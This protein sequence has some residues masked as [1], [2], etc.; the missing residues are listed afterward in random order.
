MDRSLESR[1]DRARR[2]FA[3]GL[4][5]GLVAAVLVTVLATM[6]S[7]PLAA[8]ERGGPRPERSLP[9]L[10][11]GH[12]LGLTRY[13]SADLSALSPAEQAR[14][15][16][17]VTAG[18]GGFT[19]YVDW[20]DLEP[21]AGD[22]R[23]DAVLG[24]LEALDA[25]GLKTYLNITVGDIGD[26]NLPEDLPSGVA[27]DDPAVTARFGALLDAFVPQLPARGVFLLGLG[28]EID[29]RLDTAPAERQAYAGFIEAARPHIEAAAPQLP[30]A[31]T[32]TAQALRERSATATLMRSMVDV[33]A[34]NYAPI[35][36]NLFVRD[37]AEIRADFAAVAEFVADGPIVIQELTCPSTEAMNASLNWQRNCFD[38]ILR[39][40]RERPNFR[41]ASV[42]TLDDF[43]P[44]ECSVVFDAFGGIG[45]APDDF[46]ERFRAYL[47]HLG[48]LEP[49]GD[50][51]PAWRH[52][53]EHLERQDS[54]RNRRLDEGGREAA[55]AP[56]L[57]EVA[58]TRTGTTGG[59][60]RFL[61]H[62]PD[63]PRP[64]PGWPLV[65]V[66]HG[67]GGS[68]EATRQDTAFDALADD[69]HFVVAFGEA[70]RPDPDAPP[71][72]G[73]NPQTWN[74]GSGRESIGAVARNEDDIGYVFAMLEEI[75]RL[76]PIDR[77]RV[78]AT[79]FSNGAGMTF[80]LARAAPGRFA[81]VAPVAGS[82]FAEQ[83]MPL[84]EPPSLLYITG[85]A[86]PLNPLAGGD[87]FLFGTFIGTKPPVDTLIA[88]WL[89]R[90]GCPGEAQIIDAGAP[91]VDAVRFSPCAD[92][93]RLERWLLD[94]HGHHWP[95][96][97]LAPLPESVAGPDVAEI[98]ASEVIWRF[99]ERSAAG[100]APAPAGSDQGVGSGR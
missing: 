63:A 47:C 98:D 97:Q 66:F 19:V 88:G 44:A 40:L 79:G 14:L 24:Q 59:Q 34:F 65:L 75:G 36:A 43:T 10:P 57:H 41:F 64:R 15:D 29:D 94:G 3:P 26:Y 85:T 48:V 7:S 60:R 45:D 18:L 74:D 50:P 35:D 54:P 84:A 95:G 52:L 49:D 67:G 1:R 82:D 5:G 33:L 77:G 12:T 38:T 56:G 89:D 16:E 9:L 20:A 81:A 46:V 25:M 22:Y 100:R 68:A 6:L 51:K 70:T 17:A 28:N 8:A 93:V 90:L 86:D 91:S 58:L 61:L 37:I 31:V 30:L 87:V 27:L 4:L 99:F 71:A 83:V 2:R 39:E 62:V 55:P 96:G 80:Q 42:F 32:L 76:L 72:F 69:E 11:P 13:G 23:F 53:L 78:Y 21:T 73:D 92:G